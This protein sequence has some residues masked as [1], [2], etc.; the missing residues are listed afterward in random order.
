MRVLNKILLVTAVVVMA[1]A[2]QSERAS[3][4]GNYALAVDSGSKLQKVKKVPVA[5]PGQLMPLKKG[6]SKKL[7]GEEA[8]LEANKKSIKQASSNSYINSIMNFDYISGALYQIYSA[9]LS[10]TDIQFQENEHI[11]AV[12]AGDTAR[13]QVSK[14]YSGLGASRR[15]HLLVKPLEED[16]TNGLVVTTDLRTYHM[17]LNST[18]KTYMASVS[19]RYPDSDGL[20]T[21]FEDDD[22]VDNSSDPM[23]GVDLSRMSFNYQIKLLKGKAQD[24]YPKI[25]FHDGSKTYIKFGSNVQDVPSL[26]I[27]D[28]KNAEIVNY[29][30][31]GNYYIVDRVVYQAQL[32]GGPLNHP[33]IVQITMKK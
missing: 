1:S 30:V 29:R 12:G 32:R 7:V 20:I 6:S 24:W 13:W 9:P 28:G 33:D 4:R 16:L 21:N 27:M 10:V 25:V 3:N 15:E 26:F 5:M 14:T 2:C 19:W 8:T 31:H 17:V 18:A 22:S 23:S 11:V